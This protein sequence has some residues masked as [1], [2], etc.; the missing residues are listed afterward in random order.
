MLGA[1]LPVMNW[2]CSKSKD[3][4]LSERQQAMGQPH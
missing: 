2:S 4:P 3:A 1:S